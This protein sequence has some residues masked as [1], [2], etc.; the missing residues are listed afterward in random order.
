MFKNYL[1]VAFRNLRRNKVFSFINILGLA[2]GMGCSLLI[3][4]WVQDE[5][6]VDAFH[7]NK[8]NL[9]SVYERQY[10]DGKVSAF[11][12]SPGILY[13]EMKKVLPEVKYA[14]PF[15]WNDLNTFRAGNK[16]MKEEGNYSA[17]DFFQMFNYPLLEGNAAT[18][19]NSPLSIAVSRKMAKDFFGSPSAAIGKT[20]RYQD[21]KD[22]KITAVFEDLPVHASK[23]FDYVLNWETF[24]ENND[25]AKDWT[26]NG[27]RT[28]LQLHTQSDAAAFEKKFTRFL[29]NYNKEQD[30]NFRIE[31]GIQRFDEMYLHSNF[32]DGKPSG[33]RI[34]YV[35]LFSL[36]AIFIL[37]IAS[38]NFMNLSTARSVK[39]AKEIGVRKVV[40]AMKRTLVA[41]FIGEALLLVF[42]S[43]LL[44]LLLVSLLLPVFNQL[45]GKQIALPINNGVFWIGLL[46]L[47]LITGFVSGSYPALFLSSFNPITVLKGTLK[48]TP[49]A[50]FMRRGLVVF[51]FVLS[52]VLIIGTIVVSRQVQYVQSTN[53]GYDRENFLYIPMEGELT[54]KYSVFKQEALKMPGIQLVTRISQT[55]TQIQNGT[56]GVEW[57]GKDP[58]SKPQFTQAA[59]GY[60]FVK[61][62]KLKMLEGRDFSKD[63]ASDSFG[64]ILNESA[65]KKM[66][67]KDPVGK[68]LT[69]WQR[70][71]TIIGVV[72]DFHFN[73][74]HQPIM[75]LIM[76]NGERNDYGNI[77]VRTQPGQTK[78][79]L[80]S[81][82]KLYKQLNPQFP[83][84]YQFS[85]EEYSKL[86]KSEQVVS[87]LST[88]FA[89]LAIFISC[90]GVLGLAIFTAEQRTKE[91]GIRKVL[92]AS[93]QGIVMLLSK[94]FL[95][96]VM[97]AL[98]IASPL[99][100][101]FMNSWLQDYAYR[102]NISWWIFIAAGLLAV[103]I[104]LVTIGFQAIKAAVANPVKSLRTE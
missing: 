100:W 75:P 6:A 36:V 68:P 89:F 2:L 101:Y 20:I 38:I 8:E 98:V 28:Y 10:F 39:R 69:F 76:H 9:Y 55:P 25:W 50:A 60:D 92:G 15:A 59:V 65:V 73:S 53:L 51:Q 16:I 57:E 77:L 81:L 56:G 45:T 21:R 5:K 71:G 44:S 43:A 24:L 1:L 33:G 19:L 93:V 94:D 49:R 26:N 79:A 42:F 72:K 41:Q 58:N 78:T 63:L 84:T 88:Y 31:L 90:L 46:A 96:L 62:M 11:H 34:Q 74:L 91:I 54:T 22:L 30:A 32:L 61:T 4:L 70:K 104:T 3:M 82:G 97:I 103:L 67:L 23:K 7:A 48:F 83:F 85:D 37:I 86:Y 18:A 52:I 12:Q 102:V 14:A 13:E 80:A 47:T 27:P 66:G 95:K 17:N 87:K 40:G 35:K 64:Y 99:A 29:D